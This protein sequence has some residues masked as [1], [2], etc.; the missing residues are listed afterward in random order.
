MPHTNS[1]EDFINEYTR[2]LLV[3]WADAQIRGKINLGPDA[4][5]YLTFAREKGWVSKK[6]VKI[7]SPGFKAAASFLRR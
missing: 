6:E 5:P 4:E 1:E 3:A 7:L 2:M